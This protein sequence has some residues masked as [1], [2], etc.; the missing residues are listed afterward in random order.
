MA[1]IIEKGC[2][3]SP[4]QAEKMVHFWSLEIDFMM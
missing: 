2:S 4:L 3:F 1:N